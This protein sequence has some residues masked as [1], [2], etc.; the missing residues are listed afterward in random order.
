MFGSKEETG[1]EENS[2]MFGSKERRD[3]N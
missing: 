3:F 1:W 2:D